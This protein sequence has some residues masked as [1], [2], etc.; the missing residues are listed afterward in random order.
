MHIYMYLYVL[1]K[2]PW[3]DSP[4]L[5]TASASGKGTWVEGIRGGVSVISVQFLKFACMYL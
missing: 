2:Y 4:K 1:R 5:A 3:K